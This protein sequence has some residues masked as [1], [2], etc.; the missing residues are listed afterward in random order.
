MDRAIAVNRPP[1]AHREL[2]SLV[3]A[4]RTPEDISAALGVETTAAPASVVVGTA[5]LQRLT[6]PAGDQGSEAR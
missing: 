3:D 4:G 1:N 6:G 5:K 2:F